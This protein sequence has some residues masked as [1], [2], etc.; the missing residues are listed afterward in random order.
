MLRLAGAL[1]DA[2]EHPIAQAIARAAREE[3]GALPAVD[4][5]ANR[6]GLGVEGVVDGPRRGR[7]PPGVAGRLGDAP[8]RRS[9]TPPRAAAERRGRTAIAVGWDG[10]ARAVLVV[11]DT[12]KPT[13]AEAVALARRRSG[14]ARCC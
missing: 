13:S 6:E 12:V 7:R 9:S 3:L 2:S 11:A 10:E 1:E 8:A 4:G 14:C 5:F